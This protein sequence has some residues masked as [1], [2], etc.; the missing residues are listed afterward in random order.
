M[1]QAS[2]QQP[3][4]RGGVPNW[5]PDDDSKALLRDYVEGRRKSSRRPA[6]S[7]LRTECD[8]LR[9]MVHTS[10]RLGGPST[11]RGLS[12][13]PEFV[14]RI[15][16]EDDKVRRTLRGMHTAIKRLIEL[17]VADRGH[18]IELQDDIDRR[19]FARSQLRR[20]WHLLPRTVGG[21]T[22]IRRRRPVLSLADLRSLVDAAAAAPTDPERDGAFMAVVS[23]SGLSTKE[24]SQLRWEQVVEHEPLEREPWCALIHGV[25][26]LGRIIC[27]PVFR[28][29]RPFLAKLSATSAGEEA[30]S[31]P[32][33][34]PSR[35]GRPQISYATALLIRSKR[36]VRASLPRCDDQ[37]L[38][39]AY[40]TLLKQ[41][42]LRDYQIR[43]ALGLQRMSSV[44]SLLRPQRWAMSQS[45]AAELRVI[46]V[47][48]G[49]AQNDH[50][51]P[52]E[53]GGGQ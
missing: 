30:A 11:L 28:E 46:E 42:G 29:A 39:R 13:S 7:T 14:A 38:K 21:T 15:V 24:A 5:I 1:K 44:D 18:A 9:G 48:G 53:I 23:F 40:S 32:L 17:T 25:R 2:Q 33:F 12:E 37:S 6:E 3:R 34:M 10:V 20:S 41:A 36:L 47:P 26:R 19:L 35:G 16:R 49:G 52:L 8:Y 50:Q 22:R 4:K 45:V 51:L 31:G 43:D 27:I